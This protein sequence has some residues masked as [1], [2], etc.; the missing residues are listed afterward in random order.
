MTSHSEILK[1]VRSCIPRVNGDVRRDLMGIIK[2]IEGEE[3][4]CSKCG[5]LKPLSEFY[6]NKNGKHGK[7]TK[8]KE[9]SKADRKNAYKAK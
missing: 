1:I 5:I 6:D 7:H 8:C 3:I 4:Q 2:L 9:C